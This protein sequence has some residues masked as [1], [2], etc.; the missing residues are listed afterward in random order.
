MLKSTVHVLYV[1]A[2]LVTGEVVYVSAT[3]SAYMR[4]QV[5][6][7][8]QAATPAPTADDVTVGEKQTRRLLQQLDDVSREMALLGQEVKA[9]EQQIQL[10]NKSVLHLHFTVI[11][12]QSAWRRLVLCEFVY[13]C[14]FVV[15]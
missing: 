1:Y 12:A 10:M 7:A 8:A 4:S 11:I 9:K 5:T 14:V 15:L 3:L 2:V 13:C 6:A